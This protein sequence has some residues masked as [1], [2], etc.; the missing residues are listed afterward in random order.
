MDVRLRRARPRDL[1]HRRRGP[2]GHA[3]ATT[4]RTGSCAR[5]S[6][7]AASTATRSAPTGRSSRSRCPAGPSTATPPT[8]SSAR[9]ASGCP[10]RRRPYG[11]TLDER[12]RDRA[13]ALPERRH[14]RRGARR[15]RARD[16]RPTTG[17]SATRSS[18]PAASE[19]PE[20]LER[21]PD[22]GSTQALALAPG[23]LPA[24]GARA[25]AAP[26]PVRF[27]Y[28]FDD[29]LDLTEVKLE[30]GPDTVTTAYA[31]DN[32]GHAT[33]QGP[34]TLTRGAARRAGERGRRRNARGDARLRLERAPAPA[35]DVGRR[36]RA[37]LRRP[38]L[39]RRGPGGEPHR[40]GRRHDAH[41]R[42]RVR[43]Q[44]PPDQGQRGR[45]GRRG[46]RLRRQRQP[47]RAH[48]RERS[49]RDQL[50]RRAGPHHAAR[51]DELRRRRRRLPERAR[52]RHVRLLA[53]RRPAVGPGG[54]SDGRLRVRR[55]GPP[56][57]AQRRRGHDPVPLR[58]P[59]QPVP[60][61]RDARPGRRS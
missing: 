11:R 30:S 25:S 20:P 8:T 41:A 46:L 9:S 43:R 18:Y 42:L 24:E 35:P 59:G 2:R 44:R 16:R 31:Y 12:R 17:P 29:F 49:V 61:H 32:D 22:G 7:A 27:T 53:I 26:P 38:L 60:G 55:A 37:L 28:A 48:A 13:A 23:R 34:F 50:V 36:L 19:Q 40:E 33:K 15:G 51:R 14:P 1:A 52:R 6:R 10:A 21:T 3:R 5:R 39:R 45:R 54:R 56:R 58:Q 47:H 4:T 57:R